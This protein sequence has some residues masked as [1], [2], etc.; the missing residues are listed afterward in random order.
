MDYAVLISAVVLGLS[1]LAT[2]AKFLD[3]FLHSDPKTMVRTLRLMMVLL[4]AVGIPLLI[5]MIVREQWV[6]AMLLGAV[7]IAVATF[8]RWNAILSPF[9]VALA[10][11]RRKPAPFE[12]P[13]LWPEEDDETPR[14]VREAAALLEA[15]V[16]QRTAPPSPPVLALT[17]G[18]HDGAATDDATMK[19]REALEVLGLADGAD[20]AAVH[21][22]HRRLMRVADPDAGGSAYLATRIDE[23]RDIL[24]VALAAR[25]GR[26]AVRTVVPRRLPGR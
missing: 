6:E 23:A 25:G 16:A 1:V 8:F 13:P 10:R 17:V 18:A 19:V 12:M 3:W 2:A 21:A 14:S 9:R 11:L 22:A 4:V 15:Y 5:V 24:V 20:L 7:M 26:A